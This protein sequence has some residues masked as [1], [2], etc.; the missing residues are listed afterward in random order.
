METKDSGIDRRA[1][2][3][4]AA[5]VA[6]LASTRVAVAADDEHAGHTAPNAKLSA[7]ARECVQRGEE[8]IAHCLTLFKS[9]NTEMA[10]C[11]ARVEELVITCNALGKLAT[12]DSEHL[13]TFASATSKICRS[14]E[15]ECRKHEKTHAICRDCA[16]ACAA[17]AKECE[18]V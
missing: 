2:L 3:V 17:C 14:C 9:G 1:F 13:A 10:E 18:A 7:A 15:T 4:G 6:A 11:A 12:L 8:C 5:G 16:E